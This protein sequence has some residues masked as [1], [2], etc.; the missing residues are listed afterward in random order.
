[1]DHREW[2]GGLGRRF[3]GSAQEI[4]W[5]AAAIPGPMIGGAKG[6]TCLRRAVEERWMLHGGR[7]WAGIRLVYSPEMLELLTARAWARLKTMTRRRH[8]RWS[9]VAGDHRVNLAE[10][11]T[12]VATRALKG[13]VLAGRP[14]SDAARF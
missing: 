14:M 2:R 12:G 8:R 7:V 11:R 6:G 9:R 5:E 13:K 10:G 4:S 1:M 3:H